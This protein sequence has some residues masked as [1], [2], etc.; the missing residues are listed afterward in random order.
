[1]FPVLQNGGTIMND[2]YSKIML[3]IIAAALC[4]NAFQNMNLVQPAFASSGQ[5]HKIAICNEDGNGCAVITKRGRL[6]TN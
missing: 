5:V 3:T 6:F 4:V 1:M 2:T